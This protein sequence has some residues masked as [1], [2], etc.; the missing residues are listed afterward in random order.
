M[1]VHCPVYM[2]KRHVSVTDIFNIEEGLEF[3]GLLF[4]I[5][6]WPL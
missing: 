6:E 5:T 2:E 3:D 1:K 4:C